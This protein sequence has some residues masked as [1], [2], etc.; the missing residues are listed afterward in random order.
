M[1]CKGIKLNKD[2]LIDLNKEAQGK[3]LVLVIVVEFR[4][5]IFRHLY[6]VPILHMFT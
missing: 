2:I 3:I 4:D 5:F 1:F 6:I